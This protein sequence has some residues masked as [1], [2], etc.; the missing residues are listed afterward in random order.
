MAA[1]QKNGY[2]VT[3]PSDYPRDLGNLDNKHIVPIIFIV[4][5]EGK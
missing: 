5:K 4:G 3:K 2:S 1:M